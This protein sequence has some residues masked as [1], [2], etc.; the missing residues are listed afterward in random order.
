MDERLAAAGLPPLPRTAWLEIDLDAL[1]SNLALLRD[2]AG[3]GVA[4]RP[5]VK[6][7]AYGHGA[8]PVA[9]ALVEA[10]ADGLCVATLDEALALRAAPDPGPD[11]RAVPDPARLG[12]RR[13][14]SRHRDQR[15]RPGSAGRDAGGPPVRATAGLAPP[16]DRARGRDGSRTRRIRPGR[17]SSRRPRPSGASGD[18]VVERPL[19]A[20][21]GARGP[22]ADGRASSA[23]SRTPPR[24]LRAA[25]IRLP[26]RH[27]SASVGLLTVADGLAAYDGV[28][29]GLAIYGLAPE[30]LGP[31][32]RRSR[33]AARPA[34]GPLP[35]C[36]AGPGRRPARRGGASAT[37]RRS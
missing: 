35:A 5:V 33:P 18:V 30:E 37:A 34:P 16:A 1:A 2:A 8:L 20:S 4:V 24:T 13:R 21:A 11:P 29:P 19:D 25:G 6:A 14:P 15:R 26:A 7:D 23:G 31:D 9:R 12:A 17:R 36:P 32:H 3:P 10:G 28:R 22:R 27:A